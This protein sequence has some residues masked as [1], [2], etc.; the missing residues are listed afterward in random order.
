MPIYAENFVNV[1]IGIEML[2]YFS[3]RNHIFNS[4]I[5]SVFHDLD[6]FSFV[7]FVIFIACTVIN[8][9]KL[10]YEMNLKFLIATH[11]SQIF[12]ETIN[13]VLIVFITFMITACKAM[14]LLGSV[15]YS[16]ESIG[17]V[18]YQSVISLRNYITLLVSM[19]IFC[20]PY[21]VKYFKII[22]RL[23]HFFLGLSKV[24]FLLPI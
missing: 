14:N 20:Y 22:F 9:L 11:L 1:I 23:F 16:H 4:S 15:T 24:H 13:L 8:I 10:I 5:F 12:H 3:H 19:A 6:Y 2:E 7:I 21:R 18:N 17:Y